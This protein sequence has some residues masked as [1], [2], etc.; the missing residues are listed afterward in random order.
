MM[1]FEGRV[2]YWLMGILRRLSV[3]LCNQQSLA[4]MNDESENE[5][6]LNSLSFD[7][8]F[9]KVQHHV[10][11]DMGIASI[12]KTIPRM[13]GMTTATKPLDARPAP[14]GTVAPVSAFRFGAEGEGRHMTATA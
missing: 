10:L 9:Y 1:E 12:T 6:M 14:A 2:Q 13:L 4:I 11:Q 7:K 5:D 3:L 8:A